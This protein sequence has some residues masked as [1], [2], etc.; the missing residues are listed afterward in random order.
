MRRTDP[1]RATIIGRKRSGGDRD[2]TAGRRTAA[3]AGPAILTRPSEPREEAMNQTFAADAILNRV[4]TSNPRVPG[5]VAMVTDRQRNIY[6]GAAGLRRIDKSDAMTT[7]TRLRDLLDHQGDHRHRRPAAGRGGQARPRRAGRDLCARDRHAAGAGG[8]RRR[9][10][11][12][13]ARA[14][15]RRSPRG[16][17][18]CTPPASATTSSTRPTSASPRPRA[19]PASSPRRA[20]RSPR[21]CCSIPATMGIR[22]QHRLVR[23][24]GRGHHRQAAGRGVPGAHL[25]AARHDGHDLRAQ[26]PAARPARRDA[27]TK[28]RRLADADGLRAAVRA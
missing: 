6:E 9:R 20:R 26:R 5:V 18:C 7:D 15:A 10:R 25:R 27:R 28:R 8:L 3:D 16:C 2:A 21:R 23:A 14:Q 12:D 4:V 13:P 24:G 19:S 17:C 11:P 1:E 22:H